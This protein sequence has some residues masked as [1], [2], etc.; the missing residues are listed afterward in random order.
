MTVQQQLGFSGVDQ[1]SINA[2]LQNYYFDC[3]REE[4]GNEQPF[5]AP[6]TQVE[7]NRI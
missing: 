4:D 1:E 2:L 7:C 3:A 5:D 6:D